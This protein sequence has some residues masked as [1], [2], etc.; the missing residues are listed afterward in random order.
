MKRDAADIKRNLERHQ[1][2]DGLFEQALDRLLLELSGNGALSRSEAFEL[3]GY[4][5]DRFHEFFIKTDWRWLQNA[6][7]CLEAVHGKFEKLMTLKRYEC[8]GEPLA[9]LHKI[10]RNICMDLLKAEKSYTSISDLNQETQTT[11]DE[12][13]RIRTEN[14]LSHAMHKEPQRNPDPL[15][16]KRMLMILKELKPFQRQVIYLWSIGYS[17]QEMADLLDKSYNQVKKQIESA[18]GKIREQF[19]KKSIS[20]KGVTE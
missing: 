3:L 17:F 8:R 12:W 18:K 9:F 15:A 4:F 7:L 5:F 14:L 11:G 10:D 6:D 1:P 13:E 20:D 2:G 19:K 16:V